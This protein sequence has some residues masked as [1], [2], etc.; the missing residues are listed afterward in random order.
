MYSIPEKETGKTL[1]LSHFA[2]ECM[3][4]QSVLPLLRPTEPGARVSEEANGLPR[5]LLCGQ[6]VT[7]IGFSVVGDLEIITAWE[8]AAQEMLLLPRSKLS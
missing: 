7:A 2:N 4:T 3:E 6:K 8:T 1:P 5:V